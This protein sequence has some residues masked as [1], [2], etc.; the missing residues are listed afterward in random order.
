M[1]AM[2]KKE[3][4]S[5]ARQSKM[6]LLA[7]A[8]AFLSI[9]PSLAEHENSNP[10]TALSM[11]IAVPAVFSIILTINAMA[12]E[13]KA[14][15]DVYVRSLPLS[16]RVIV[17]SRY[18]LSL[19][20]TSIG[21][22]LAFAAVL[23]LRHGQIGIEIQAIIWLG[24]GAAPLLACSVLLPILYK[25]GLQK[26]RLFFFLLV[27]IIPVLTAAL[28]MKSGVTVSQATLFFLLKLSPLIVFAVVTAS[29]FISCHIYSHK[30]L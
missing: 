23:F 22:A 14:N 2:L 28:L 20:L 13:E 10:V 30:E 16:I 26:T 5:M 9:L 11:I 24:A 7:I 8:V 25:F 6:L 4:I 19:I 21:T 18:I 29:F 27:F 15:W 12:Y 17:G 3:W 1:G